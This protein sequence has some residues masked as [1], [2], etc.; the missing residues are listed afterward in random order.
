MGLLWEERAVCTAHPAHHGSHL[1]PRPQARTRDTKVDK[2]LLAQKT[3]VRP[4]NIMSP[5]EGQ[6]TGGH[7]RPG[8]QSWGRRRRW[9]EAHS[10]H[11]LWPPQTAVPSGW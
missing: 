10:C 1:A 4:A 2:R 5:L 9:A 11:D 6:A 7:H 3:D 8:G